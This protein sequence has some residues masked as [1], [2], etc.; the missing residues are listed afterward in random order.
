M[1]PASYGQTSGTTP[2]TSVVDR[3]GK[4][5]SPADLPPDVLAW[6]N[7]KCETWLAHSPSAPLPCAVVAAAPVS[8][9]GGTDLNFM[10]YIHGRLWSGFAEQERVGNRIVTIEPVPPN[11]NSLSDPAHFTIEMMNCQ[12][13]DFSLPVSL[14]PGTLVWLGE[15]RL[16]QDTSATMKV[17]GQV[18]DQDHKLLSV[19][20]TAYLYVMGTSMTQGLSTPIQKGRFSFPAVHR[21]DDYVQQ[22]AIAGYEV[23]PQRADLQQGASPR[24]KMIATDLKSK[25]KPINLPWLTDYDAAVKTAQKEHKKIFLLFTGGQWCGVCIL[26]ERNLFQTPEFA[27]YAQEHLVLLKVLFPSETLMT[28]MR[29]PPA[30]LDQMKLTAGQKLFL[31]YPDNKADAGVPTVVL[32]DENGVKICEINSNI[33]VATGKVQDFLA[34]VKAAQPINP[35]RS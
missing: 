12:A 13:A 14:A 6:I 28:D 4:K 33:N 29:V 11:R 27:R 34:S 31:K 16:Q 9:Q 35:H 30:Q 1:A 23:E 20:G 7:G 22:A 3:N 26:A 32:L 25:P 5:L 10:A 8:S 2:I 18:T 24:L 15:V 17:T 21:N 19:A